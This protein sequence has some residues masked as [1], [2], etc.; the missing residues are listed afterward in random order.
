[1]RILFVCTANIC[2]SASA[3]MLLGDAIA[4]LPELSDVTVRSA[5]TRAVP[6]ATGCRYAP[7]LAGRAVEHHAQHLDRA[8]V[9][10][11]DLILAAA[12]DHRPAVTALDPTARDRILTIRQAGRI[13]DWILAEGMVE[14]ARDRAIVERDSHRDRG[15][16][17]EGRYDLGDP[18]AHVA[19]LPDERKA[20]WDWLVG[21]LLAGR[22]MVPASAEP[23]AGQ[24]P[25]RWLPARR[26]SPADHHPDDV[27]D[28][29]FF[30]LELHELAYEQIRD[31][32][33]SLVRLLRAVAGAAP[34]VERLPSDG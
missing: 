1:M 33:E 10:S 6:G 21:E 18:R 31:S 23:G 3:A 17:W 26:P 11:A 13:A 14:V 16:P 29:H 12:R 5:G 9:A 15:S 20:R 7:A 28:P 24:R 8:A 27:A 32:V 30:G 2:R 34:A 25:S 19:A 22:G 4:D